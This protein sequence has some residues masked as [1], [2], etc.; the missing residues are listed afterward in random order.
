MGNRAT[1]GTQIVR[2]GPDV[3]GER[4]SPHREHNVKLRMGPEPVPQVQGAA[5]THVL[6]VGMPKVMGSVAGMEG[7]A[8]GG[9]PWID[10]MHSRGKTFCGDLSGSVQLPD[11]GNLRS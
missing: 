3:L 1:A 8:R 7:R 4:A 5:K 10:G 9:R 11:Q 6:H 2:G